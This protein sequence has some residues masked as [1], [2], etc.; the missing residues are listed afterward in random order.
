MTRRHLLALLGLLTVTAMSPA[1][2]AQSPDPKQLAAAFAPTGTLRAVINLGNPVLARRADPQAPATGVSVDLATELAARLGVPFTPVVVT[3]AGAAVETLRKGD[4]DLGFFAIDPQR[5]AGIDFSPPYVN[6]Y[7][8]YA[9]AE[10]SP[11]R[12]LADVDRAGVRIVV[13]LNSAYDLFLTR[14]IKAA[15]LVRAPTSPAV[16]AT[17]LADK[18]EVAAGVRQQIEADVVKTAGALRVL[19]GNFMTINQ[20]MG[21][22]AGRAPDAA[23]YL[24]RFVEEMK[25]SGFVAAA[26][27]RH[28][29]EGAAV[30]PAG[31]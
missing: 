9:V 17:M 14:E 11:I 27:Q 2:H 4:V 18:L 23:A 1:A 15:T 7:G 16:V 30:A 28:R 3:S 10:A 26:L 5:S 6:I 31:R 8:A 20:A 21:L 12:A 24:T 25:A 13:G 19:P 29:I 22:A